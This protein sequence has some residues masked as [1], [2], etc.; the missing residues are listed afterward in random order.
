MNDHNVI[1]NKS[2]LKL[3][4]SITEGTKIRVNEPAKKRLGVT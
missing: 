3:K 4:Y 2:N 1:T